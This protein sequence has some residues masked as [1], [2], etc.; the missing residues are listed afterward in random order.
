MN[1]NYKLGGGNKPQPY[2]PAGN[3]EKSGEYTDKKTGEKRVSHCYITKDR[4]G[5]N[6][7]GSILVKTVTSIRKTDNNNPPTESTPYSVIQK[8]KE[9]YITSERYYNSQGVV[10]LDIDYT[11]HGNSSTHPKV[12]HIHVWNKNKDGKLIRGKWEDFI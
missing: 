11:D 5:Y 6:F 9:G 4:E 12:P 8:I 3:G 7:S 1:D 2:I 10:Y